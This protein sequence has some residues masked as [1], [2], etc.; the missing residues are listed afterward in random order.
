M[1]HS[2]G[3][4]NYSAGLDMQGGDIN[5][6]GA[7]NG[8][9]VDTNGGDI[10]SVGTITAD[11][12][13]ANTDS[14][15]AAITATSINFGDD[16]LSNYVNSGTFTPNITLSGGAGNTTPVYSINNAQYI[17]VGGA[18]FVTIFLQGDGGAEGAGTGQVLIDLPFASN[19]SSAGPLGI[20]GWYKN[21]GT[22]NSLSGY[23]VGTVTTIGLYK[24]ASTDTAM[25]GADQNNTTREIAL[26]FWYWV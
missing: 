18:V 12:V 4:Q 11:H 9:S 13:V 15:L 10:T 23:C 2:F 5:N 7:I 6:A 1:S 21:G 19:A 8:S 26:H 25:T 20:V 3:G 22:V 14:N 24:G 16:T 17:R